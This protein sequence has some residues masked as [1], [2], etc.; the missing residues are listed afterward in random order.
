MGVNF[1]KPSHKVVVVSEL[2]NKSH[3]IYPYFQNNRFLNYPGEKQENFLRSTFSLLESLLQK[4]RGLRRLRKQWHA[5]E[6]QK[7]PLE[8]NMAHHPVVTWVGHATFLISVSGLNILT[9]PIFGNPSF[10]FPRMT[11]PG[12][13]LDN[14][15][16]IDVVILSHNHFDHMH[17]S[18]LVAL[19]QNNKLIK[20]LVP[21]GDKA[22]FDRRGFEHVEEYTW[23]DSVTIDSLIFTFLPAIHWSGR[24]IF[25]RNKSLW[26]SWMMQSPEHTLYFAGDTAYGR[27]FK[28]IAAEFACIDTVLMPIGPCE[29]HEDVTLTHV[30]AEQAGQAFLDLNAHRFIPMHW[31]VFWFGTDY[32]LLPIERLQ[33]WW[34]KNETQL[35]AASLCPLKFGES[36]ECVRKSHVLHA[37]NDISPTITYS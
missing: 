7:V 28:A 34:K 20:I 16:S 15:P 36:I 37:K 3:R 29:P 8:K 13:S 18:T 22:W 32:P 6:P 33:T 10:L 23:W 26:G 9:D 31:G 25:D 1:Y 12:L 5:A 2:F 19:A 30:N 14:L 11:A 4:T 24:G 17:A 27:H 21:L 35:A